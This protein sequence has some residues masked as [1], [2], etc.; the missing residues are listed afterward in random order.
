MD[1]RK[2]NRVSKPSE[3]GTLP[4][5][6]KGDGRVRDQRNDAEYRRQMKIAE[7]IVRRYESTLRALAD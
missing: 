6:G 3:A 1:K 2:A 7:S 5:N 4:V